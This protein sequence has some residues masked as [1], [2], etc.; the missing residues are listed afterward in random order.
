[1]EEGKSGKIERGMGYKNLPVDSDMMDR[2]AGKKVL[3][4]LRI[5]LFQ[6]IEGVRLLQVLNAHT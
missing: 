3:G 4:I 5:G 2:K 1:M 6:I